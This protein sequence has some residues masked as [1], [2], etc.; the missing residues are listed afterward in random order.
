VV[1]AVMNQAESRSTVEAFWR[2]VYLRGPLIYDAAGGVARNSY[3]QPS[4]GLPFGRGFV[5]GPDQKVALALFGHHPDLIIATIRDLLAGMPYPGD[6][7]CDGSVDFNDIDP[8]VLALSGQA[9]Y[10]AV[11]PNCNW[12]NADCNQDGNVNFDDIDPFVALLTP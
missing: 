11:W 1:T 3:A 5:I 4:T 7:N 6:L 8:F 12:L 9:A 2:N 10:Y